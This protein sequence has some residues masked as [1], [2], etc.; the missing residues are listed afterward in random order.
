[1]RFNTFTITIGDAEDS[2]TENARHALK[3][4]LTDADFVIIDVDHGEELVL[5]DPSKVTP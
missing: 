2:T 3:E 1:M 4:A 5:A